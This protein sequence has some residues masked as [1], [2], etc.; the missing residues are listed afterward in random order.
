MNGRILLSACALVLAAV[1]TI[2]GNSPAVAEQVSVDACGIKM[3]VDIRTAPPGADPS[4]TKYLGVFTGGR[5][6]S[7]VCNALVVSDVRADGTATVRYIFTPTQEVP[8][9]YF[10]KTDA[11][12]RN[13]RLFF[14][15][16]LGA[17]VWY[18]LRGDD[19]LDGDF[20]NKG[21]RYKLVEHPKRQSA[22]R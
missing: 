6:D 11:R 18:S 3:N 17:E 16:K 15:S 12:F 22:Q 10:E 14:Y 13:D 7:H 19:S 1:A 5:W 4:L 21:Y 8:D 2:V 9:G 20:I